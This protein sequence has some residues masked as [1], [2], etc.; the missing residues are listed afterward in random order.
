MPNNKA[1]ELNISEND[2]IEL[3]IKKLPQDNN[4]E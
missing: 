2:L 4:K 3:K 1:E